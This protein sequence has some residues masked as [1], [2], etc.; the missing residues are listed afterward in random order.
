MP[1]RPC[2]HCSQIVR[3]MQGPH[4]NQKAERFFETNVNTSYIHSP[5]FNPP[6]A[7]DFGNDKYLKDLGAAGGR[8]L[9]AIQIM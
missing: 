1:M 3:G 8:T 4:V 2:A 6:Y 5:I 7:V 9:K